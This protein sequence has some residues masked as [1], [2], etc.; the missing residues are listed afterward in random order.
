M[1]KTFILSFLLTGIILGIVV[2]LQFKT[3]KPIDSSFPVDE[4][5]AREDLI[6]DF[7][8]E[9]A[10]FQ[11]RIIS[12]RKEISEYQDNIKTQ[13][14]DN[15]LSMLNEL[16]ETVGL[17]EIFGP[18]LEIVLDDGLGG[19]NISDQTKKYTVQASDLRDLINILLASNAEGL[20]IN[21]HRVIVSSAVS[22]VGSNILLNNAHI[23]PPF[24]I[25]AI[26][27][28]DQLM[29]GMNNKNLLGD[30][31]KRIDDY[32]MNF[33][34]KISEGLNVPIYSASFKTDYINLID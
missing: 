20:S 25:K 13:S 8:D 26:G 5:A 15:N 9:Q 21:N 7:L 12:L 3:P 28:R 14:F 6:K 1:K 19:R 10:Y 16:K 23:A 34:I 29:R 27:D 24:T 30:L 32:K 4:L 31:Y 18:G 2:V 17:T 22:S 11:S 33:T